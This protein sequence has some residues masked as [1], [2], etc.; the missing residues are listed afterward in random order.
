MVPG[1]SNHWPYHKDLLVFCFKFRLAP[2]CEYLN[3]YYNITK[4]IRLFQ[5][6]S[7]QGSLRTYFFEKKTPEIFSFISSTLE[8]LFKTKLYPYK[9]RGTVL[10]ALEIPRPKMKTGNSIPFSFDLWN[11]HMIFFQYP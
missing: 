11:F 3:Y 9:F 10:H 6:K 8:I 4:V 1:I 2:A 5:K 7:K